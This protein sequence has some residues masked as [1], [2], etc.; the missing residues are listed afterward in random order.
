MSEHQDIIR[1]LKDI[2]THVRYIRSRVD[3]IYNEMR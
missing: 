3:N 2:E 1:R